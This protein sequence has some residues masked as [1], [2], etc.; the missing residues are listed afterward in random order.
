MDGLLLDTERVALDVFAK[1]IEAAGFE[2][3]P[4]VG[5]QLIGR[6]A[7]DGD[8]I[9]SNHYGQSFDI[10]TIRQDFL[11]AY[12]QHIKLEGVKLKPGATEIL[13][14]LEDA[15]IPCA[16]VT[17]SRRRLTDLKLEKSGLR[18]FF[19]EQICGDEIK[20]GKP[21]PEG[22]LLAAE[23]LHVPPEQC[24]VLED[25][26]PGVQAGMAAGMTAW[27]I[28]DTTVA[29]VNQAPAEVTR[30]DDLFAVKQCLFE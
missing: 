22:Y 23:K 21:F 20:Q 14:A 29:S 11:L 18:Q 2:W 26:G 19:A 15:L 24:L 16:V 10:K 28:P 17:S 7:N 1:T 25:S 13:L 27:W 5:M 4:G 8:K 6:N 30:F 12:E 3:A 9:L